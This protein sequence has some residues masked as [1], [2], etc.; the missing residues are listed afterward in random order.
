MNGGMGGVAP[1]SGIDIAH[2][3]GDP[4]RATV[5]QRC[6]QLFQIC[7]RIAI[8]AVEKGDKSGFC[9]MQA[10]ISGRRQTEMVLPQ[11][12]ETCIIPNRGPQE[13]QT[14]I[15]RA[16]I[17]HDRLEIHKTLTA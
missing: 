4:I 8:I 16:V 1:Q 9:C 15:G 2:P 13:G 6:M 11:D 5:A 12:R 3:A 7:R 14:V 10:Q 17:N